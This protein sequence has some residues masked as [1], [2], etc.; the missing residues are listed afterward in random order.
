MP[1]QYR[2]GYLPDVQYSGAM[3]VI[4]AYRGKT[5]YGIGADSGAF[6]DSGLYQQS[7]VSK[8]WRCGDTLLG[9]AGSGR[10]G[11]VAQNSKLSDPYQLADFLLTQNIAGEWSLLVVNPK[12]IAEIGDDGSVFTFTDRYSAIGAGNQVALGALAIAT[13]EWTDPRKILLSSLSASSHHHRYCTAPY[14][15]MVL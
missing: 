11:H 8:V 2:V 5:S 6:E 9:A 10:V 14:T 15:V 12:Q 4:V 7:K 1:S 13:R 3:S